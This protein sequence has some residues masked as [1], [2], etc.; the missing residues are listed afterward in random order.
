MVNYSSPPLVPWA[1]V[2]ETLGISKRYRIFVTSVL[3]LS[4]MAQTLVVA[5]NLAEMTIRP[6]TQKLKG[7]PE[8]QLKALQQLIEWQTGD[9]DEGPD[10]SITASVKELVDKLLIDELIEDRTESEIPP[11]K[12]LR[13]VSSAPVVRFRDKVRQTLDFLNR[14]KKTDRVELTRAL[15]YG[16]YADVMLD[17]RNLREQIDT[18]LASVPPEVNPAMTPPVLTPPTTAETNQAESEDSPQT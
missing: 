2:E 8:L 14:L 12:R 11:P 10:Q 7:K 4:E 15:Q 3:Q 13:A 16:D 9:E 1:R 6:I 5:H 18:I 17:L